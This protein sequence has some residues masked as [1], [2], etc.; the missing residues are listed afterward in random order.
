METVSK[1][2]IIDRL[3]GKGRK[4]ESVYIPQQT[5][6]TDFVEGAD[7]VDVKINTVVYQ[8]LTL[9]DRIEQSKTTLFSIAKSS[10]ID[11]K[12]DML[13]NIN[14]LPATT[15]DTLRVQLTVENLSNNKSRVINLS[16]MPTCNEGDVLRNCKVV[17][18]E[19]KP[20]SLEIPRMIITT[21][22]ESEPQNEPQN[23]EK[24]SNFQPVE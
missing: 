8:V 9:K 10:K 19:N 22:N 4:V 20:I 6:M 11:N 13:K 1:Q 2:D 16:Y 21:N 7:N 12:D 17:L 24:E 14:K 5:K 23:T 3:N 18:L 15:G